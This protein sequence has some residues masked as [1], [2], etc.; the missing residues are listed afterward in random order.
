MTGTADSAVK[1]RIDFTELSIAIVAGLAL[2]F[3]TLFL[4]VVPLAGKIAASRDFVVFWATG[5]QLIH[6]ADPYDAVA[7]KQIE[8]SAGLDPRYGVLFMRNPPW[9]LPL[10]LP[11]G[12]FGLRFGAFLWSL[13]IV[14]CL[15]ASVLILWRMQGR[16]ANH[17]HWIALS[18]GPALLCAIMGQNTVFALFG[19]VLFLHL[20]RTRPFLAGASLWLCALKPHLFVPFGVVL[21]AWIFISW[22]YKIL[23]GAAAAMAAS[24]ALTY[25]VDPTAWADYSKMMRTAGLD[26]EFIPCL[27]V[28]LQL[29]LSPHSMWLRYL[30][31]A[32]GCVW[33]LAYYWPRRNHWDWNRNGGLV[34][35]VSLV[36]APY[37]WVYDGGLAIPA[38]MQGAYRTRSRFLLA[39][40]TSAS[41]LVLVEL[42]GG[43][44]I[45]SPLY[46][47]TAPAW[48]A[49]YLIA[50]ATPR[51]PVPDQP[52][53]Q[54]D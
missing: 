19:Y 43:I 40:L 18:F 5:R 45:I 13:S 23:A 31:P 27:S 10:M 12:V 41:L 20:H 48:L 51:K 28:A 38:L 21:L 2:A 32:L 9:A 33:A 6:H 29:W 49:W 39:V 30:A 42:V 22:S 11:L 37:S 50:C 54:A 17:L 35:L 46:L 7:M 8:Q 53:L 24:V 26:T 36:A 34:L 4:C 44:R 14:A 52:A 3:T 47:W 16:P 1:P 15:V 25:M